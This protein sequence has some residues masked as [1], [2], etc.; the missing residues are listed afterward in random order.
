M[1]LAIKEEMVASLPRAAEALVCFKMNTSVQEVEV[2]TSQA[3][4]NFLQ[5]S[6]LEQRNQSRIQGQ[7]E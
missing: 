7:E 5:N 6:A 3:T 4:C 1:E 2:I